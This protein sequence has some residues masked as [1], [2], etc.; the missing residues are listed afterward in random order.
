[1]VKNGSRRRPRLK[2]TGGAK[3]VVNHAG[4]RLLADMA[5]AT[6]LTGGLSVAMAPTKAR[7]RGWDRGEVL[8]DVA[9]SLADGATSFS[10]LAVLADQPAVFGMVASVPTAWRTVEAVDEAA[11]QRIATAR[12]EARAAVW[13]VGVDPGFY[14]IDIDG[15]LIGSHSEKQGAAANYKKGFGFY[16]IVAYLDATGEALA[17]L[18]RPGNAGSA[19]AEDHKTVL[20]LSLEQLPVDPAQVEVIA[21]V[22]T[23]GMS[24]GFL[25]HCRARQVRYIVGHPLTVDIAKV[26]VKRPNQAWVPAISADGA[27]IRDNGEVTEITDLIDLSGWPEG[28]RMIARREDPHP[29]AQLSFT[30]LDGHRFGVLVTD[31]TDDDI[32]YLEALYRGRGRVE[33]RIADAKD[34]AMANLPS[35]SFAI[36]AAWL[37]CVLIAQDLTTWTQLLTLEGELASA[38]PK[39]LRYCLFHTAAI[40][41][42][43]GRQRRLRL[44]D[45]WPWTDQLVAAFD[46]L[47]HIRFQP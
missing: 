7:Q 5:D 8:V 30:D 6:G 1:M 43:N 25:D 40:I 46:R 13:A 41:V 47:H 26:L 2:V 17:G 36:N 18:L 9:V 15:T 32:G 4:T 12:A 35:A 34:T 38:Q 20:D 22:D 44:A 37:T 29:G 45:T 39:R 33:C 16:P 21:R 23:A 24:H 3:G 10:D 14:V 28:T 19:T 31:L 27:E 42:T 11:A